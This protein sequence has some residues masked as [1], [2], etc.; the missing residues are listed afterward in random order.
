MAS[1][2]DRR[3]GKEDFDA[4]PLMQNGSLDTPEGGHPG[5]GAL[6]LFGFKSME[7]LPQLIH[8]RGVFGSP[9]IEGV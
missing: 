2:E 3:S 4:S 7:P 6:L 8:V 1:P 5:D 9:G